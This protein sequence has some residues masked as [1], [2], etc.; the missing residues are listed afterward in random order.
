MADDLAGR[1]VAFRMADA[2]GVLISSRRPD[3]IPA[4]RQALVSELPR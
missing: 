3:D 4:F 1:T 2:G